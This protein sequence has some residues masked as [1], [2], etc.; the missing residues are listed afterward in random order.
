MFNFL[1]TTWI[2]KILGPDPS[3]KDLDFELSHTHTHTYV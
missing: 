2:P 3:I 1:G